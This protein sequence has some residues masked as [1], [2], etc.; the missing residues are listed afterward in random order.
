VASVYPGTSRLARP[1]CIHA[2]ACFGPRRGPIERDLLSAAGSP[3]EARGRW[4]TTNMVVIIGWYSSH[5]TCCIRRY[6][7]HHEGS[8]RLLEHRGRVRQSPDSRRGL[9]LC[10]F[11]S[12]QT[13]ETARALVAPWLRGSTFSRSHL[14]VHTAQGTMPTVLL[15]PIADERIA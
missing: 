10:S 6:A 15:F 13:G 1:V 9:R 2:G 11:P 12:S 4:Y 8:L 5:A 3:Q 14:S 7:V